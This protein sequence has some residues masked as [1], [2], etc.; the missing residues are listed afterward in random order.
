MRDPGVDGRI[1][2]LIFSKCGVGVWNG[3]SWLRIETGGRHL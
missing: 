1:L 3:L 2:R